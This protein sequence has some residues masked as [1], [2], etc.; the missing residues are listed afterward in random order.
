MIGSVHFLDGWGFDDSRYL[1]G[2]DARDIDALY[3]RYF[4]LVGASAET[5]LFDTIGHADLV[6]KFGHRPSA[7]SGRGVRAAGRAARARWRV[8][9]GQ[10]GRLAQTVSARS[11]RI[12]TCC[13]PASRGRADDARLRC[14]RARTKSPPTFSA[15]SRL[16]REVGLR[17]VRHVR[18]RKYS[19][20]PLVRRNEKPASP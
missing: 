2:F 18:G 7:R 8:R 16:M 14:P 6:K 5:G 11:T 13:A 3:A 19:T 17:G 9:R 10:H 15:A 1:S 12:P 4:D 20:S